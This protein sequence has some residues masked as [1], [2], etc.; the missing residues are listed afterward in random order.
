MWAIKTFNM[1]MT[2]ATVKIRMRQRFVKS[3]ARVEPGASKC[4]DIE[5]EAFTR[6]SSL[7]KLEPQLLQASGQR[8][9]WFRT[10]LLQDPVAGKNVWLSCRPCN[11]PSR[12]L[13]SRPDLP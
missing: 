6:P 7:E 5:V 8:R 11:R 10:L 13:L 2:A 9:Y 4:L 12:H 1:N 3:W